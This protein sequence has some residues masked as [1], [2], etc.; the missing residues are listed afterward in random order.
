MERRLYVRTDFVLVAVVLLLCAYGALMIYSCTQAQLAEAREAPGRMLHLQLTWIVLGL[1]VMLAAMALDYD[2]LASLSP[3]IYG[4]ALALLTLVLIVGQGA[5]GSA[6]W[7]ALGPIRAQPG[8]L[9]KLAVIILLG[10]Y[11][12]SRGPGEQ[13]SF[14]TVARSLAYVLV[15]AVMIF[16]Q[17]DLGTPLVL[18]FVWFFVLFLAG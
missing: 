7:L 15:P 10:S 13:G 11:L 17:P 14:H 9:A 16:V 8:E 12:A 1:I 4:L 6:R 3:F 5:H 18:I 2:R